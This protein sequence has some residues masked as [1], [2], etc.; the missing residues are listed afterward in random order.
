MILMIIVKILILTNGTVLLPI[1]RSMT[2]VLKI[3]RHQF[4]LQMKVY[5]RQVKLLKGE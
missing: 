5:L 4:Q 1:C 2:T 3:R